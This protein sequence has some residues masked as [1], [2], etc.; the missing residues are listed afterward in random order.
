MVLQSLNTDQY[1]YDGNELMLCSS[2]PTPNNSPSCTT[3]ASGAF[4]G[5]AAEYS[6]RVET[7]QRIR[8]NTTNNTWVVTEK[9]GTVFTYSAYEGTAT[10]HSAG[11]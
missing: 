6:A 1:I 11:T 4:I 2:V 10:T 3:N 9:N 8:R 5:T 7:Y